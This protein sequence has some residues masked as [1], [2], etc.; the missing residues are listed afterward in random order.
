MEVTVTTGMLVGLTGVVLLL[1]YVALMRKSW[2]LSVLVSGACATVALSLVVDLVIKE[3]Q[4]VDIAAQHHEE[5]FS[6]LPAEWQGLSNYIMTAPKGQAHT[7][8]IRLVVGKF[9][10]S[11]PTFITLEQHEHFAA[12]MKHKVDDYLQGRITRETIKL[13]EVNL[14]EVLKGVKP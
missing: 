13:V 2:S 7:P 8:Q 12:R 11:S 3:C 14:E 10:E 4:K 1:I 6:S 9:V 5:V